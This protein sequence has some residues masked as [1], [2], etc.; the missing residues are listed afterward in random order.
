R[1]QAGLTTVVEVAE[2]EGLLVQAEID[3]SVARLNVWRA[4]AGVAAAQGNLQP[5]VELLGQ[6][7]P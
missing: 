5:F 1:Y 3:D 7:N 6:R 2:S 4:L